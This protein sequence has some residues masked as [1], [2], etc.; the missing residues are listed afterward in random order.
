MDDHATSN[1]VADDLGTAV[2]RALEAGMDLG[3]LHQII[4][5]AKDLWF[6]KTPPEFFVDRRK[7]G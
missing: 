2:L 3:A 5:E 6:D 1:S 7:G 4:E